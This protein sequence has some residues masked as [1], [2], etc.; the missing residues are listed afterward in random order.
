LEPN[1]F[2]SKTPKELA[3]FYSDLFGLD[4]E[5]QKSGAFHIEETNAFVVSFYKNQDGVIIGALILNIAAAASFS[6]ALSDLPEELI[7]GIIES[8][9][10]TK[11]MWEDLCEVLNISSQLFS[12]YEGNTIS[13]EEVYHHPNTLPEEAYQVLLTNTDPLV[14]NFSISEYG[15][16]LVT[17]L[18]A[19]N[20]S[21]FTT[22]KTQDH[23]A[24]TQHASPADDFEAKQDADKNNTIHKFSIEEPFGEPHFDAIQTEYESSPS[25]PRRPWFY[26]FIGLGFGGLIGAA[27]IK[28]FEPKIPFFNPADELPLNASLISLKDFATPSSI[29]QVL[30]PKS[31]FTMGCTREFSEACG[32]DEFPSHTVNLPND[33]YIM[34]SEVTQEQY[35][36]ITGQ[37]PSIFQD[38]GLDCPVENVS[39]KDSVIFANQLSEYHSLETCYNIKDGAASLVKGTDCLGYRL[40]TEAEWEYAARGKSG[41]SKVPPTRKRR[42]PSKKGKTIGITQ[43][44][45]S[46]TPGKTAWY[47]GYAIIEED[48]LGRVVGSGE[49]TT[50][51]VCKK[52]PNDFNLCDMSG[53]VWEWIQDN[54]QNNFYSLRSA[55]FNPIGSPKGSS[56]VLR[57]G[58]W[59]SSVPELRT[60]YRFYASEN[61]I[62]SLVPSLGSFGFRLV[63]TAP[64]VK[65]LPK[66]KKII[67]RAASK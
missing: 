5:V 45:G 54:Y 22:E 37:N 41:L 33:Y 10:F 2:R 47:G 43:Y 38:C 66:P 48:N 32:A 62:D 12:S 9:E 31:S 14:F 67:Q 8:S 17:V 18:D 34:K 21:A 3:Q 52:T 11:E 53:N 29:E 65:S 23:Q 7:Q 56:R 36:S 25:S 64:E 55:R 1:R 58:S 15:G 27:A 44:S 35:A 59:L 57:G 60:S 51:P 16:G 13:V 46:H 63:R 28:L 61:T 19:Q 30:I 4:V 24:A 50:H 39:W 42:L 49:N 40:P 20:N 6:G 26:L